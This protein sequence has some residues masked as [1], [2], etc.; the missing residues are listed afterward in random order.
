MCFVQAM[1]IERDVKKLIVC[2]DQLC[3]SPTHMVRCDF[4]SSFLFTFTELTHLTAGLSD[5]KVSSPKK[6]MQVFWSLWA[7]ES[8]RPL[9]FEPHSPLKISVN[10]VPLHKCNGNLPENFSNLLYHS[11]H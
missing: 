7:I 10:P 6:P 5:G 1:K 2:V 8:S 3:K 9:I 4:M 11:D